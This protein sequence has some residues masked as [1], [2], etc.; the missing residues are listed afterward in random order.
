MDLPHRLGELMLYVLLPIWLAAGLLDWWCHRRQDLP[1]TTGPLESALHLLMIAQVGVGIA[2]GLLLEIN[3]L[4][5]AIL[6][7]LATVHLLTAWIDT[8]Y[9]YTRREITPLEQ[10]AHGF[11]DTLPFFA[12]LLLAALNADQALAML[13]LGS[14]APVWQ[15]RIKI[16][17]I[18]GSLVLTVLG[19]GAALAVL[20][21]V[22]E[23]WRAWRAERGAD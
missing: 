14:Q 1:H 11:L 15:A 3:A 6:L 7:A 4:A 23:M 2:I 19:A 12:W 9:S 13:G 16:S 21:F 10:H 17:P 20:P 5:L 18:P 8:R 22:E